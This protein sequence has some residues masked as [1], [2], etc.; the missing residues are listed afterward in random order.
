MDHALRGAIRRTVMV[1]MVV[2]ALGAG[3]IV[4]GAGDSATHAS[5]AAHRPTRLSA[6]D[7]LLALQTATAGIYLQYDG[8]TGPPGTTYAKDAKLG[9]FQFG[10][11]RAPVT[12]S[13]TIVGGTPSVSE[14]TVTHDFD[15]YSAA[16]IQESLTGT[17]RDAVVYFTNLNATNVAVKYLEVDLSHVLVTSYSMSSGGTNPSESYSLAFTSITLIAHVAGSPAQTVTY[18][19]S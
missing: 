3:W 16:L 15:K 5:S 2:A 9:S 7:L 11:N 10:I 17:G 8:I 13:G 6:G 18:T 1:A 14:I 12:T 19:L 4:H